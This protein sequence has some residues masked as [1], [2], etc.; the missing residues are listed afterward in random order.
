MSRSRPDH[1]DVLA[2]GH[3][4]RAVV[5]RAER[6]GLSDA[7][8]TP[9]YAVVLNV[10]TAGAPARQV[11]VPTPVPAHAVSCLVPGTEVPVR[12]L[13]DDPRAVAVDVAAAVAEADVA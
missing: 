13:A 2:R 6:S 8:G 12:V 4:A 9:M 10:V 7:A 5:V 3:R 1:H 11:R